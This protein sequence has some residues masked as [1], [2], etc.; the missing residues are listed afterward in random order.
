M[1]HCCE[2]QQTKPLERF[3]KS[4]KHSTGYAP[5]C[6]PCAIK[7][8]QEW[9]Q[10]NKERKRA[11][12]AK[13]RAA[14]PHLYRAASKRFRDTNPAKKAADNQARRAALASRLPPWSKR[15]ECVA[16]YESAERVTQ[17]LGIR[18]VVDHINPLR[19][20]YV[21]GLHVPINLRVIP[22]M[23]NLRKSNSFSPD[24]DRA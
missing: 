19:G 3:H 9:Y 15:G 7:V 17:C 12:D 2:C 11:Y 18:H 13:R 14:K 22:E 24:G 16:I 4:A 10:A 1:K 8:A 6:I 21:S 23:S 5:R 20:K